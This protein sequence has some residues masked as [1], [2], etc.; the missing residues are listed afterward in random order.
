MSKHH[1]IQKIKN[2]INTVF[3]W[4]VCNYVHTCNIHTHN[5]YSV[6][7][8]V[9]REGR[10]HVHCVPDTVLADGDLGGKIL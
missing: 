7:S 1:E 6:N 10:M 3:L 8:C 5:I 4:C 2:T 9:G